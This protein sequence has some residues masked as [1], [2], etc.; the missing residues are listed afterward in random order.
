M[1]FSC[2]TQTVLWMVAVIFMIS[3]MPVRTLSQSSPL[4]IDIA[5]LEDP[6]DVLRLVNRDNLLDKDYPDQPLTCTNWRT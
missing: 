6:L 2:K 1:K 3:G 5:I 4:P